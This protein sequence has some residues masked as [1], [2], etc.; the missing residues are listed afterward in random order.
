[1]AGIG[2]RFCVPLVLPGEE[3]R[4]PGW[5]VDANICFLHR[6]GTFC[7][8]DRCIASKLS[9]VALAVLTGCHVTNGSDGYDVEL[10][11]FCRVVDRGASCRTL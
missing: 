3:D 9:I 2:G 11:V 7:M 6:V 5:I 4:Y 1:M 10:K 8:R